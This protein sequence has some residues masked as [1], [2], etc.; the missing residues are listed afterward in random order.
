MGYEQGM[1]TP[2]RRKHHR[3]LLGLVGL[4][5]AGLSGCG[6]FSLVPA[7]TVTGTV[8]FNGAPAAG[9]R[10][11]LVGTE[12]RAVTD[13]NGRYRFTGLTA[14]TYKVVYLGAADRPDAQPNEVAQWSTVA[15]NG[16]AGTELPP[17]DVAY[18][19]LL[20]PDVKMS[21]IVNATSPVPFHWS[22]HPQAKQYRL[23]LT[24]GDAFAWG[25]PWVPEPTAIFAQA[26]Q[27]GS[28]YW[29]VEID[30]GDAGVGQTR[31]RGVDL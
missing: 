24:Q 11:S 5:L 19:G 26:V 8:L 1:R 14:K 27:P 29:Q 3:P 25:G 12:Q 7:G 13:A 17:F 18:S 15:F 10:V 28:Y 4:A 30:A 21:L 16:A 9:K 31:S 2:L 23:S 20:Y 22:T 6:W